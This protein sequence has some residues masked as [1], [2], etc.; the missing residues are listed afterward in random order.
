MLHGERVVLRP[1]RDS[2]FEAWYRMK[3]ENVELALLGDGSWYPMTDEA[4]R[5]MW[6]RMRTSSPDERINFVIE[7]DGAFVGTTALKN[8][9]RRS[10]H[11][12]LS[13][14]LRGDRLG[15][16]FGRDAIRTLL[17]WA[18]AIQN[19]HRVSL[20]TWAT[21]ERAIKAY[22]AAG[23]VEEGRMREAMW[24]DGQFVDTVQMGVLRREWLHEHQ[25]HHAER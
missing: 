2:D 9:D 4:A 8:I 1:L 17:R 10:Q 18:F 13:I 12:W 3:T 19:M 22:R 21:N 23:F 15:Q 7:A 5:S 16:G 6:Q 20:E 14:V 11:G 24:V 25:E